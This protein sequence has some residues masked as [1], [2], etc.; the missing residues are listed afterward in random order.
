M[1]A[2]SKEGHTPGPWNVIA[3]ERRTGRI[4]G[5]ES[6]VPA[7]DGYGIHA[8]NRT[9]AKVYRPEDARLIKAAPDLL[10]SLRWAL[11]VCEELLRDGDDEEKEQIAKARAAIAR[12]RARA[13]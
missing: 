7:P 11:S 8:N 5:D 4:L 13:A 3:A 6:V 9:V 2:N 12:A 10:E 1:S